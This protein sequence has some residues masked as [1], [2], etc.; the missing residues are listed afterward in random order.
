MQ[1]V[2]V[3]ESHETTGIMVSSALEGAGFTVTCVSNPSEG[4]EQLCE[5]FYHLIVMNSSLPEIFGEDARLIIRRASY[6][7]MIVL[8]ESHDIA[9]SLEL[10]ADAFMTKP[11]LLREL[12]ARARNLINRKPFYPYKDR[13]SNWNNSILANYPSFVEDDNQDQYGD[14]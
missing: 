5:S 14:I 6:L 11:P 8:G 2:L 3:I 7:P 10:G 9:Q 1:S 12:V 4:L 13:F